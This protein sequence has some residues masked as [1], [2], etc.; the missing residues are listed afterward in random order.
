VLRRYCWLRLL[1]LIYG[2]SDVPVTTTP[3]FP[4]DVV[5]G[6]RIPAIVLASDRELT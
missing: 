4:P 5:A 2:G 6:Y 3:R 1:K